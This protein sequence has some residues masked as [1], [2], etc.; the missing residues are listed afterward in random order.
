[1]AQQGGLGVIHKNLS[2]DEQASEVR[3]G[4]A[5]RERHDRQPDHAVAGPSDLT[6]RST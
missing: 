3:S 5:F 2:I 1:M 6:K 4:E